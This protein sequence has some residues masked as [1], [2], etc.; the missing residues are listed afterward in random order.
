MFWYHVGNSIVPI[1]RCHFTI[2][3]FAFAFN[4]AEGSSSR[5]RSIPFV[6]NRREENNETKKNTR[7]RHLRCL[8][9][10]D[11]DV[12][13][14]CW[15]LVGCIYTFFNQFFYYLPKGEL[16]F[17]GALLFI[18][19]ETD[20]RRL[21]LT[22]VRFYLMLPMAVRVFVFPSF[23]HFFHVRYLYFD[24]RIKPEQKLPYLWQRTDYCMWWPK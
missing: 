18:A 21:V 16:S 17:F 4:N 15:L 14:G 12:I 2:T 5:I 9:F 10:C 11:G 24:A 19:R 8:S 22:F 7:D 6:C 1:L 20:S 13:V 23:R 3:L